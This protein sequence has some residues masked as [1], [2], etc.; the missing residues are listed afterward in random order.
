M[1]NESPPSAPSSG[2]NQ[3]RELCPSC[4]APNHPGTHFCSDCGAPLSSYAATAPFVSLFAEGHAYRQAVE[5]PRNW[6][7]LLG[8]WL[9]FGFFAAGGF[10][11]LI[12]GA[13][14]DRLSVLLGGLMMMVVSVWIIARTTWNYATRKPVKASEHDSPSEAGNRGA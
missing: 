3:E 8:I 9:L 14:A 4:L 13:R 5:K 2:E 6:I 1:P 7:V 12:L 10:V 11:L